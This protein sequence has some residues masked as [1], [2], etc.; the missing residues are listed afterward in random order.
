MHVKHFPYVVNLED[1]CFK[2][3]IVVGSPDWSITSLTSPGSDFVI[4]TANVI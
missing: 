3:L 4:P 1:S 2:R